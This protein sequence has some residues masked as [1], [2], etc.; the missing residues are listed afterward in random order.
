MHKTERIRCSN[1]EVLALSSEQIHYA[2]LDAL[3]AVLLQAAMDMKEALLPNPPAAGGPARDN[4]QAAAAGQASPGRDD[5]QS[6]PA[7]G[8]ADIVA[9]AAAAILEKIIQSNPETVVEFRPDDPASLPSNLED[10]TEIPQGRRRV[11]TSIPGFLPQAIKLAKQFIE[12][13]DDMKRS[14]TCGLTADERGDV[15]AFVRAHDFNPEKARTVVS[16][17]QGSGDERHIVLTRL[18]KNR[19]LCVWLLLFRSSTWTPTRIGTRMPPARTHG[20]LW[21][22][23]ARW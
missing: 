8:E 1:W 13:D 3:S 11:K 2:A 16:R 19:P 12:D 17:S 6:T 21:K 22:A 20:I 10:N 23:Q 14:L 5:T 15:H 4:G 18:I 7:A 9:A